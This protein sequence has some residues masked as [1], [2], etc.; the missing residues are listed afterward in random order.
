[1][2]GHH[3][4]LQLVASLANEVIGYL[5]STP[6]P[7]TIFIASLAVDPRYQ[8]RGVASDL[9]VRLREVAAEAIGEVVYALCVRQT[10]LGAIS[11]Y[12][13]FGFQRGNVIR[14]YFAD[15][16]PALLM[17]TALPTTP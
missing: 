5:S 6:L 2:L 4:R 14:G 9:L 10:N 12:E 3:P 13:R 17:R 1:M 16:E 15:G 11:L 8:R 7:G